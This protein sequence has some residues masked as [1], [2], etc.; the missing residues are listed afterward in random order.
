MS[1]SLAKV[2]MGV[3]DKSMYIHRGLSIYLTVQDTFVSKTLSTSDRAISSHDSCRHSNPI[4]DARIFVLLAPSHL[5]YPPWILKLGGL[6]SSGQRLISWNGKTKR[7]A[8][9]FSFLA[10]IFLS[11]S[12]FF[13]SS[14]FF[15][16]GFLE[17]L[18]FFLL[19]FYDIF[20]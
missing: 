8:L 16:L 18:I 6:E 13:S 7:I 9:F 17:I 3:Q 4:S 20:S 14:F 5:C 11:S 12:I 19:I 1:S 15:Y 10:N 2:L